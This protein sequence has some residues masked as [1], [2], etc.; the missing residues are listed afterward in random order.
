MLQ[1]LLKSFIF[2]IFFLDLFL[3]FMCE[4]FAVVI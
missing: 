2:I 1:E 3:K 4:L